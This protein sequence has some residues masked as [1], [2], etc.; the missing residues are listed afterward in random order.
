MQ[1]IYSGYKTERSVAFYA[2]KL[3]ISTNYLNVLTNRIFQISAPSLIQERILLEAKRLL[4][5]SN[6]SVKDIVFD[7]GFY[8][9]VSF[10]KFFRSHTDMTPSQFKSQP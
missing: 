5:I 3:N 9:N 8:D 4:K 6:K 10:S 2:D 7:Q 1:L